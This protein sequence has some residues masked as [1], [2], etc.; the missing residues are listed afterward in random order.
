VN[1]QLNNLKN[2]RRDRGLSQ[3]ELGQR[4][5]VLQA[6][7]ARIEGGTSVSPETAEKLSKALLC[8]VGDLVIPREPTITLKLSDLSPE[9]LQTLAKK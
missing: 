8:D 7:V 4:I 9:M 1:M 5:G 2:M 3:R 6:R